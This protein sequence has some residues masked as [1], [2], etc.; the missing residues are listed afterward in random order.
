MTRW[1]ASG[2]HLSISL[3]IGSAAFCLLYLLWYSSQF[4]KASGADDLIKLLLGVDVVIGPLLTWI[5]YKNGKPSLKFDLFVICGLQTLALLY[6]LH[7]MWLA[8]PVFL[9]AD[10]SR[11]V[12]VRSSDLD[13]ATVA[14]AAN[15]FQKLSWSGPRLVS[16]PQAKNLKENNELMEQLMLGKTLEYDFSR[17][18]DYAYGRNDLLKNAKRLALLSNQ[19][20]ANRQKISEWLAEQKVDSS[21]VA[22]L[23]LTGKKCDLTA[24]IDA[25]TGNWLGTIDIDG[26]EA[27]GGTGIA[28]DK[29]GTT[30]SK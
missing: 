26:W 25:Q 20:A 8:R 5:V 14:R 15:N 13:P 27:M 29:A 23:P 7:T 12:L 11:F 24:L 22:W 3:I 28:E 1:K 19:S 21:A 17:Y 2:I 9:V 10:S 30:N 6:G 4:F 16:L 18:V